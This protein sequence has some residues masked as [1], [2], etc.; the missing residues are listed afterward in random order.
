MRQ[1][2][3]ESY[4]A[5]LQRSDDPLQIPAELR[6]PEL[7]G[8]VGDDEQVLIRVTYLLRRRLKA[9]QLIKMQVGAVVRLIGIVDPVTAGEDMSAHPPPDAA[10]PPPGIPGSVMSRTLSTSASCWSESNPRRL[11][12]SRTDSPFLAASFATAAASS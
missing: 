6:E 7:K 11:T 9:E 2:G 3:S 12:T 4:I 8:L 1:P 5:A 10:F